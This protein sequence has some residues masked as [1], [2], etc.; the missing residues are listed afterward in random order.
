[1][2]VIPFPSREPS[3]EEQPSMAS[4]AYD[5]LLEADVKI[6]HSDDTWSDD[7]EGQVKD[8]QWQQDAVR[9]GTN[10]L[11]RKYERSFSSFNSMKQRAKKGEA[12]VHPE[13][14]NFKS[15]FGH[16]GPRRSPDR[17]LDRTDHTNPMYGPGLCKW[18]DK[19][20]QARNRRTTN[21]IRDPRNGQTVSLVALAEEREIPASRLRRQRKDGWTDEEILAGRRTSLRSADLSPANWSDLCENFSVRFGQCQ[22]GD[23]WHE[24]VQVQ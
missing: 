13:F 16:M 4:D 11:R 24:E 14:A 17:T 20:A 8:D 3:D 19:K 10:E 1:M 23:S 2:T 5:Q 15:F 21:F 9:L 18:A 22:P 6:T 12:T 7:F